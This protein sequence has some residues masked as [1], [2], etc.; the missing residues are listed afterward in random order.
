MTPHFDCR[1]ASIS[2]FLDCGVCRRPAW[3]ALAIECCAA[4]IALDIHLEDGGV[5][6]EAIDCGKGHGLITEHL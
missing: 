4:S 2:F 5:M 3:T 6:D 1:G